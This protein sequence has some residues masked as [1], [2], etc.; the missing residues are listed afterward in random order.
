[1][2][3]LFIRRELTEAKGRP[4]AASARYAG[5]GHVTHVKPRLLV[6]DQ[7]FHLK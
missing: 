3:V 6:I 5:E 1:M 2:A 4:Q 7:C